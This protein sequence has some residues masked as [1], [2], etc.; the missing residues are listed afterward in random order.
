M[1]KIFVCIDDTDNL[2][3]RGTGDLAT[4]LA[5]EL[6]KRGW[7]RSQL[8]DPSS[9]AGAS[10]TCLTLRIIAPCVL[11]PRLILRTWRYLITYAGEYLER[12]SATGSDPGLCASRFWRRLTEPEAMVAFGT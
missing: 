3:S 8:C 10:L 4:E 2:E 11:R 12:E 9:I 5:E 1:M 7:G 6:E